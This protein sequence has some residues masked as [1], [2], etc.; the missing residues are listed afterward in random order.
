MRP[1][2]KTTPPPA[3]EDNEL[4][5]G[6]EISA[7]S[8]FTPPGLVNRQMAVIN[9]AKTRSRSPIQHEHGSTPG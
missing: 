4:L 2:P 1:Q 7:M 5:P 8:A 3:I 6:S 9:L